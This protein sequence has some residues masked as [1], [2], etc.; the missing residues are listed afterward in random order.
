MCISKKMTRPAQFRLKR[1]YRHNLQCIA[2]FI[3]NF[4]KK[5]METDQ[6]LVQPEN[7]F[8]DWNSSYDRRSTNLDLEK[9]NTYD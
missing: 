8:M 5:I 6:A 3:H 2:L 4:Q 7:I 9:S 1:Y